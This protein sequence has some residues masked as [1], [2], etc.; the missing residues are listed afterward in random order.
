MNKR[1]E[2]QL[3]QFCIDLCR[4]AALARDPRGLKAAPAVTFPAPG[5]VCRL[6]RISPTTLR[7][8]CELAELSDGAS[9]PREGLES[10]RIGSHRRIEHTALFN[11]LGRNQRMEREG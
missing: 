6:L 2:M 9:R 1:A 7:Q 5:E 10:F 8:L 3:Y 11:G 4:S